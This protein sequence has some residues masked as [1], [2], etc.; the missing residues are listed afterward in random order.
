[1]RTCLQPTSSFPKTLSSLKPGPVPKHFLITLNTLKANTM[2]LQ[3]LQQEGGYLSCGISLSSAHP[4]Q[5]FL[6]PQSRSYHIKK[7][8]YVKK[9]GQFLDLERVWRSWTSEDKHSIFS[10]LPP[11]VFSP[12]CYLHSLRA[13]SGN[14]A[15]TGW[16]V[17]EPPQ[18][19]DCVR[20]Y[21]VDSMSTV[22]PTKSPEKEFNVSDGEENHVEK[23]WGKKE[24]HH[25]KDSRSVSEDYLNTNHSAWP[26]GWGSRK[27]FLEDAAFTKYFEDVK[28]KITWLKSQCVLACELAGK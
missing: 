18:G 8:T 9:Q 11:L 14:Y 7:R 27:V 5:G 2:L 21:L 16:V 26:D 12:H 13:Q 25:E 6:T 19:S 3:S 15:A 10:L 24:I 4:I 20:N 1:M 22:S 23:V 17:L 28:E